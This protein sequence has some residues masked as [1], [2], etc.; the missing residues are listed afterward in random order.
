M[1]VEAV[2]GW[3]LA[4]LN[5]LL[6]LLPTWTV[7][8]WATGLSGA[9]TDLGWFLHLAAA[10]VDVGLLATVAGGLAVIWGVTWTASLAVWLYD[11]VPAK[12]T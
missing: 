5:W 4:A 10:W 12:A 8:T 1:I 7:P 3:V 2:V 6:G 9:L 11:R